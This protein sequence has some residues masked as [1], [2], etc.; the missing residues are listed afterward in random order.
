MPTYESTAQPEARTVTTDP[1][2]AE[3]LDRLERETRTV[4]FISAQPWPT[5]PDAH[6][7]DSPGA[8]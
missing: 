5:V 3:V 6:P 8:T 1:R 7:H 4:R 2:V